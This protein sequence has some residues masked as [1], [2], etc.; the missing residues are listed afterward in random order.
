[1][2]ALW[3][4]DLVRVGLCRLGDNAGKHFEDRIARLVDADAPGLA[5]W[6]RRTAKDIGCDEEWPARVLAELGRMSLLLDAWRDRD[7][8]PPGLQMDIRSR[9]G[10]NPDESQHDDSEWDCWEVVAQT[11]DDGYADDLHSSWLWG[12][13]S[14][15]AAF[16][17]RHH[18]DEQSLEVGEAGTGRLAFCRSACPQ[19]GRF[20]KPPEV[21]PS[22]PPDFAGALSVDVMLEEYAEDL[23]ALPWLERQLFCLKDATVLWQGN[24]F[25]IATVDGKA[26]PLAG[27]DLW[28]LLAVTGGTPADG[29]G[30]T[31]Y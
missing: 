8:L 18:G 19:R 10:L 7:R 30:G 26:V 21:T 3:L 14:G 24:S 15:R 9:I 20:V 4:E 2:F 16:E 1:M 22:I 6:L 29:G 31:G 11:V 27:E 28:E 17:L 25:L 5:A 12:M 23:A 13:L